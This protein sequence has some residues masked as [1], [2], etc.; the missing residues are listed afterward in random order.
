MTFMSADQIIQ[1]VKLGKIRIAYYALLNSQ[2][3]PKK[4]PQKRFVRIEPFEGEDEYDIAIRA[5]FFNSLKADSIYFHIGPY[6]KVEFLNRHDEQRYLAKLKEDNSDVFKI[7]ESG[8]LTVYPREFIVVG[9]NEY[10]ELSGDIGASLYSTVSKTDLGFSHISTLIDPWWKGV[11]QVGVSNLSK[12]PQ[13]LKYLDQ[14]CSVRFHYLSDGASETRKRREDW[15]HFENNYWF[16]EENEERNIFPMRGQNLSP[17]SLWEKILISRDDIENIRR[18]LIQAAGIS[19]IIATIWFIGKLINKLEDLDKI[20]D[21]S[22]KNTISIVELKKDLNSL[23]K[24][25]VQTGSFQVDFSQSNTSQD[26]SIAFIKELNEAPPIFISI[27]GIPTNQIT[28]SITY[29][30]SSNLSTK[31][32]EAT[33]KVSY[34]GGFSGNNKMSGVIK[35]LITSPAQ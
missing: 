31:Y 15:S 21:S 2:A 17:I 3:K 28:Y 26:I 7:Q 10:V 29:P 20:S 18:L 23:G 34:I 24:Q 5:Y 12:R 27:E 9:T 8:K 1:A 25:L 16:D 33:L 11:L 35:W 14:V 30:K 22:D 32:G 4:L 13:R 6:A 19:T